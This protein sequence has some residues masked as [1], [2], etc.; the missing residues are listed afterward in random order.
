MKINECFA[1]GPSAH[2]RKNVFSATI[3]TPKERLKYKHCVKSVYIRSY[4]GPYFSAYGLNTE[5]Y[6]ALFRIQSEC[7]KMR[8]RI[9][10]NTDTFYAVKIKIKIF[11]NYEDLREKSG[12]LNMNLRG[13]NIVH[14][15][16]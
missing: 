2:M 14:W 7:G 1:C 16:L 11:S 9:P 15:N 4:S 12:C 8:T 6:G 5:K 13:Q 10:P 3:E